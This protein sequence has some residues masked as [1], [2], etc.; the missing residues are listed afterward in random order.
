MG[1]QRQE[2]ALDY[3]REE[4]RVLREQLGNRRIRFTDEQRVRLAE[5]A[6]GF[7]RKVLGEIPTLVLVLRENSVQLRK[8]AV[9]PF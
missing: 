1:N 7:G 8:V 4:N 6:K 9:G 2:D 3:L 5:K